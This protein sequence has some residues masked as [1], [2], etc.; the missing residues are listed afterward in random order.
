MSTYNE[1]KKWIETATVEDIDILY[2]G[3]RDILSRCLER[4]PNSYPEDG[5]IKEL[6]RL[7]DVKYEALLTEREKKE[8][9][10]GVEFEEMEEDTSRT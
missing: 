5:K 7:A 3:I 6:Q 10:L 2:D 8:G 9:E 1:A 4:N